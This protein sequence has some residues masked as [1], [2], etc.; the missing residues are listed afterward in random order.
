MDASRP[1]ASLSYRKIIRI[2]M[3]AFYASVEQRDNPDLRG[4]PVAV[5][6]SAERDVVAAASY[7]ARKFGVRSAMASVT[8]KRQCPDLIFVK[9]RFEVYKAISRQIRDIFAEH[10]PMIEP[11]SLD[12]A[13]LDVTENL[14]GIPLARDVALRIREKIKAETGLNASAGISYNK[15]LAKLASD[16]RKPNGQY[17]ISPEMGAAFVEALPV[18]KFH[19]IGPATSAKMN[20]LGIFTGRDIRNQ[21]L[22]FMNANFGKFGAYYYWI[23]RGVDDRPV[24]ANR[25]RKSIGAENTFSADL[26]TFDVMAAELRPLIDKVWRHCES[27]GNRGR[28]V[29]LKVKFFD[30]EIITRSRSVPTVVSSRDDLESLALGLLQA[31][32]P[33]PK[34][35]RVLGVSLSSLQTQGNDDVEPQLDLSI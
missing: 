11:L 25:I 20:G 10:T 2:D 17:V 35:V 21:T 1:D 32:M 3:D 29:T 12:E 13:Y 7:E 15:F 23:S 18:G 6:G 34:A 22:K 24:R 9:P 33:L 31:E 19:G 30:L 16:H 14:E 27:T 8:A 28:T 26:T 4:K 5:G